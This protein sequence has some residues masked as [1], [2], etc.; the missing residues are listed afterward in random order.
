MTRKSYNKLS[1]R[2][3][4]IMDII[5]RRGEATAAGV[6][7]GLPDPPSYSAVR[8]TLRILEDKGVVKHR[9]EGPRYVFVPV[10]SPTKVRRSALRQ[11]L[12]TF[13]GGSHE[14]AFAALLDDARADL[15]DE[16]LSR[17]RDMVEEARRDGR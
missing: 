2:E 13:F 8:A 11:L 15:T 5:F 1:R 17:M 16:E 12:A 9:K 6:H 7:E 14:K 10:E 4:Q 3:R